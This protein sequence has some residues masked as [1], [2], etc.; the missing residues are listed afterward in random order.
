MCSKTFRHKAG[1]TSVSEDVANQKNYWLIKGEGFMKKIFYILI[2]VLGFALPAFGADIEVTI[3]V[4]D[5]YKPFSFVGKDGRAKGMYIDVLR[6]A[7][8]RMKGFNVK[9]KPV[10]WNRGKKLMTEG[11]GFGLA[12]VFYHGHDWPYLYPYSLPFHVEKIIAVCA[13][14]VLDPP[15]PN[16]PKDY[17]GLSIGN[18]AGF[19]GWGGD[20]FWA[21]VKEGKIVCDETQNS[22][23]HLRK[24]FL[25]RVDC[26]MM[27]EKAFDYLF[28]V[29]KK[30][31]TYDKGGKVRIKKGAVI[32]KD[33]VFIG[34]SKTAKDMGKYPFLS[35]F[36][37]AFDCEIYRMIKSC[38]IDKIMDAYKE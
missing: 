8:A 16:W 5:G 34:Y 24:L 9:M 22:V 10:P 28:N 29:L 3:Y 27:E 11:K 1:E 14:K 25:G 12:P 15:R 21:L 37:Q 17:I 33:P 19:E 30:D 26:I 36:R 23:S 20:K 31:G 18:L 35:E 32:G 13:E 4:D 2:L 38:E 7:F 6:T